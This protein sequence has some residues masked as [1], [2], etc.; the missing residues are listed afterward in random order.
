MNKLTRV[1]N[2]SLN[3][4][5]IEDISAE[6]LLNHFNT[7]I[8]P[9]IKAKYFSFPAKTKRAISQ[10]FSQKQEK[11]RVDQYENNIYKMF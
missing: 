7:T 10:V 5:K 9:K 6:D 8:F 2:S 1:E 11:D 3:G 4:E